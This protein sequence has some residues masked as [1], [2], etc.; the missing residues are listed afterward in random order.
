[1][2]GA[3]NGRTGPNSVRKKQAI[4]RKL[5]PRGATI[6]RRV[7]WAVQARG[8]VGGQFVAWQRD[9]IFP[10]MRKRTLVCIVNDVIDDVADTVASHPSA[11]PSELERARRA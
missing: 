3:P 8:F 2:Y 4:V 9:R 10:R 11:P 1:M 6:F 5:P 7:S